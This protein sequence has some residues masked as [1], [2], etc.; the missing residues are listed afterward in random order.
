MCST[1][2]FDAWIGAGDVRDYR[3]GLVRAAVVNDNQFGVAAEAIQFLPDVID[4]AEDPRRFV[5]GWYYN[6]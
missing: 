1:D 6:G 2:E 5:K 3:A 4:S